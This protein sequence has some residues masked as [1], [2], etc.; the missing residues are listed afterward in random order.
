MKFVYVLVSSEEDFYVEEALLSMYTLKRHNPDAE[1]IL[2]TDNQTFD[3]L[4]GERGRIKGLV[5]EFI[6]IDTPDNLSLMQTSRFIKTSIREHVKGS[7][8][9]IDN[10]TII[11]ASLNGLENLDCDLGAVYNQHKDWADHRFHPMM[12]EYKRATGNNP[13]EKNKFSAYYNGG[14]IFSRD[15][16]KAREFFKTWHN[17]W[18]KSSLEYGFHKDQPAMWHANYLCGNIITPI[19]GTF[20]FQAI[21]PVNSFKYLR[22]CK[23]FHYFSSAPI[24]KYIMFRKPE[25]MLYLREHGIDKEVG[26]SIDNFMSEYIDSLEILADDQVIVYNSPMA[27]FGRKLSER[28]PASNRIIKWIFGKKVT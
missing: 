27:V 20:N 8:L 25:F 17:L 4:S 13:E 22:G 1:I 28:F 12:L 23:I 14:I 10:D 21:Y 9:Y 18:L 2:I 7:F 16:P 6:T 19:D 11:T 15:T 24:G 3:S 26:K 5:D